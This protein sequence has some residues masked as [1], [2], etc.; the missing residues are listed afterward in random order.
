MPSS[1]VCEE[2]LLCIHVDKTNNSL[3]K[4]VEG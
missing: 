4:E 1:D 3:K 2:S